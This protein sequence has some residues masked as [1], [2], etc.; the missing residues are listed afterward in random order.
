[1]NMGS[2]SLIHWL[3]VLAVVVL[4]F[5]PRRL[6]DLAK[7]MGEAIRE[8]KKAI[9]DQESHRPQIANTAQGEPS[10]RNLNLNKVTQTDDVRT[11]TQ[12]VDVL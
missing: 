4:L 10:T 1:M 12:P 9:K 3:I 2:F 7:G 8:F 6:P 11:Q 5:G